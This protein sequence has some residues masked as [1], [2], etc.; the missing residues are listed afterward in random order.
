MILTCQQ[1]LEARLDMSPITP[2][3]IKLSESQLMHKELH[4]GTEKLSVGEL[5]TLS[6]QAENKLVIQGSNNKMD[7]LGATMQHGSLLIEGDAGHYLGRFMRGGQIQLSGTA[8]AYTA[9]AMH[10]GLIVVG[11]DVGDYAA[12]SPAGLAYGM[13]GGTLLV[14]GQAGHRLGERMRRG[15]IMVQG[16]IGD[17]CAARMVAGTI[18]ALSA[19]GQNPAFM[20]RRGT[21]LA[22]QSN[23][24]IAT[25]FFAD[26]GYHEF[27]F[28]PLLF[29]YLSAVGGQ[30]LRTSHY[31][32]RWVGDRSVNGQG[33]VL[34]IH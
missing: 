9:C 1:T 19:I 8:G 18:V 21:L 12:A 22:K 14:K 10:N 13:Q 29:N 5:F 3:C 32:H 30:A 20:M 26:C 33:E 4:Y 27:N 17:Y 6:N 11:G 7:C 34:L 25:P 24:E 2:E 16:A 15:T 28:L 23:V 31:A